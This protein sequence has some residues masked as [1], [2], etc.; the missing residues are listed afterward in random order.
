MPKVFFFSLLALL[1][2][3]LRFLFLPS[4]KPDWTEQ[5]GDK[6]TI[7][8]TLSGEPRTFSQSQRFK[9]EEEIEVVTERYPEYHYGERLRISGIL[10]KKKENFSNQSSLLLK[11]RGG[12]LELVFPKIERLEERQENPI[13]KAAIS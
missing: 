1:I 5:V 6:I 11:M 7:L 8:T 12:N 2:L 9:I 10:Q 3:V 4:P 13:L